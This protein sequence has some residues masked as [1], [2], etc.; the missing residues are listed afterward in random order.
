LVSA[1]QPVIPIKIENAFSFMP[2]WAKFPR[3]QKL[4]IK[5][6]PAFCLVPEI[7]SPDDHRNYLESFFKEKHEPVA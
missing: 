2:R 5:V 4:Y 3:R 7:F 6:K 1:K